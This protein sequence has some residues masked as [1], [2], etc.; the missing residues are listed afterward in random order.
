[1]LIKLKKQIEDVIGIETSKAI[2]CSGKTGEGVEEILETIVSDL[3][4][5]KGDQKAKLKSLLV[6]SWYDSYLGVVILVGL[7]MEVLKKE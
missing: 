2:S 1:M 5:P 7:L 4:S 6:D 3:P